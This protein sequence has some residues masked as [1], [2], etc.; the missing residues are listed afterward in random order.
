[1]HVWRI[2]AETEDGDGRFHCSEE[3]LPSGEARFTAS[4]EGAMTAANMI[5]TLGTFTWA[6]A[7]MDGPA[8]LPLAA[9][10]MC[11]RLYEDA[12]QMWNLQRPDLTVIGSY[13]DMP[14]GLR[15]AVERAEGCIAAVRV[16]AADGS[17]R[18]TALIDRR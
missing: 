14:S 18:S 3:A 9:W 1:M 15:H 8:E 12:S 16:I 4:H 11:F 13:A 10:W 5:A 17:L 6:A 7:V 2:I